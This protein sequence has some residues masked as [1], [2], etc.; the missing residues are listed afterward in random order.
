MPYVNPETVDSPKASWKLKRVIYNSGQGGWSV[1]RGEWEGDPCLGVRWNG[2]KADEGVG[3]PQSRGYPTW[4]ILPD[5]LRDAIQREIDF[6]VETD[7]TVLCKIWQPDNYDY[8]AWRIEVVLTP[9][10]LARVDN[11]S[12][13]F[14]LPALKYRMC[15]PD[16]GYARAVGGEL[17]GIFV[18]GKWAG[19]IYSN[20]IAE[21]NN[22][23]TIDA[24]REAFVE[25]VMQALPT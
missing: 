19:D 23:T 16:K 18:E 4:F 21:A 7:G 2:S 24:V 5:G 10:I 1:A 13:V 8:G 3:N 17:R 25:K 20:G 14:P 6:L 22:P 9:Q 15:H 12:L 11:I